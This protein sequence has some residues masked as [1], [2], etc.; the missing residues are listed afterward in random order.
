MKRIEMIEAAMS[1]ATSNLMELDKQLAETNQK[2]EFFER[3]RDDIF[4][5]INR[6]KQMKNSWA[7]IL[8]N[9]ET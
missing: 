5:K 8:E 4:T 6:A 2:I 3:Q 1:Q 7:Y 9:E